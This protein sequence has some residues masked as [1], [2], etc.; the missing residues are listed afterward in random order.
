MSLKE[1]AYKMRAYQ[2]KRIDKEHDMHIQA[3]LYHMA[4]ATK[5]QGKKQVP[6]FRKFQD[7]YNYEEELKKV[8]RPQRSKLF[9]KWQRMASLAARINSGRGIAD[10]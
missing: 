9:P 1:Y 2:L 7:F 5:E 10:G 6:V 4:G 8:E 3:W